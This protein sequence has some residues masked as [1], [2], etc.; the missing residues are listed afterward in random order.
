[1]T[2][3]GDVWQGNL[4]SVIV[5]MLSTCDTTETS[6]IWSNAVGSVYRALLVETCQLANISV[7]AFPVFS[8]NADWL[9]RLD[10]FD[11]LIEAVM[12]QEECH[13]VFPVS[14][15]VIEEF[16]HD[17]VLQ[18]VHFT[19]KEVAIIMDY[20]K[21]N[22]EFDE[23]R[24]YHSRRP[25]TDEVERTRDIW[26]SRKSSDPWEQKRIDKGNNFLVRF[27]EKYGMNMEGNPLNP[28][29]IICI[30]NQ[31]CS[32][33]KKMGK[34]SK[35]AQKIIND[36]KEA[37]DKKR[38]ALEKEQIKSF[39]Q[40]FKIMMVASNY[41]QALEKIDELI[42]RLTL[43]QSK[44]KI[45]INKAEVYH[46]MWVE[47]CSA[48]NKQD[49]TCA[50]NLFLTIK[51]ILKLVCKE[52]IILSD[53][54]NKSIA[55]WL[56][57]LGCEEVALKCGLMLP[58]RA[59]T[60]LTTGMS[61]VEFQLE[62]LGPELDRVSG[63][64]PDQR[65]EGFIPDEWQRKLFDIIDK[66]QS[67]LVVAPT[68][69]GKTYA[70]YY[71]MESVLRESND[72]V[73][74]YV[75]PTKALV[76][77]V[78]ATVYARFKNKQMPAGKV[79]C[80]VFT[81]DYQF[82]TMECQILVT[83]P[84]CLEIL[85]LSARRYDW[86]L[87]LRFVIL[88]E[89]HCLAGQA[90]GISWER[91]LLM[92]RCPFLALS[93]TV[94]QPDS[95]HK[96]LQHVEDFK[97]ERDAANDISR[98]KESYR[99]KL[100]QHADRHADLMKYVYLGNAFHHVHPYAFI[101]E[102]IAERGIPKHVTLSPS[103]TLQLYNTM[104]SV[105][106]NLKIPKP[107][108]Y[109]SAS[110]TG[111]LTRSAVR[112]YEQLL[113]ANLEI[114]A[115]KDTGKYQEVR[116]NLGEGFRIPKR[117]VTK[118]EVIEECTALAMA[119]KRNEMLPALVFS[120][121]R[122]L[123]EV[124]SLS[125]SDD[126]KKLVITK[127]AQKQTKLEEREQRKALEKLDSIPK[128]FKI[129]TLELLEGQGYFRNM[130]TVDSH[131]LEFLERRLLREGL[132]SNSYFVECLRQGVGYHHGGLSRIKRSAVEMMFRLNVL[133][134]VYATGTL[135]LGIHMPCRTVVLAG[136]SHYI[137]SLEYHQMSGRAGR[138]GYDISGNVVFM[139]L[140]KRKIKTLLTDDFPVMKGNFPL[141]VGTVLRILL[142]VTR[143][144]SKGAQSP[145]ITKDALSR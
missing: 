80:G 21:N 93:A 17:S 61:W 10:S 16:C 50:K 111:F 92:I 18:P 59:R 53:N 91:C 105:E 52:K 116:R 46:K 65:V 104:S 36:K 86:V 15:A 40:Q 60:D 20:R 75:S 145:A 70:S 131:D 117:S 54:D 134:L 30:Q 72:G 132:K 144:T 112:D 8:E 29:P 142:L 123:I 130:G 90:G 135:A 133:N 88:D 39:S 68:S 56:V 74:V 125:V 5:T 139:G 13:E 113:K 51:A 109:F 69:S 83:V 137:N 77:Q 7:A 55:E 99:V 32:R 43:K 6:D 31:K 115:R 102:K 124:A 37:D 27:L 89:I 35:K 58:S 45:L 127:V 107:D 84:Q 96:W 129:K 136:D 81:R 67:A 63:G 71:C 87:K 66:R 44:C 110:D 106:S 19:K 9:D 98:P 48:G 49:L 128:D 95:F 4:F 2:Y 14:C 3:V 118:E 62:H 97:A 114:W 82:K 94:G 38:E 24:H 26:N 73:V 101:D 103:E 143:V 47:V 120:Y 108:I 119:L 79:V 33:N 138:R 12:E 25:L 22:S 41:S 121:N 141:S 126:C 11:N 140:G 42:Q 23:L 1:M 57:E 76:N 78:H 85:L 28:K 64:V 34:I 100:V 122:D